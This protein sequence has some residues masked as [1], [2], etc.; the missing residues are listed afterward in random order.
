M[1]VRTAVYP[2]IQHY[3]QD[4]PN[5][6]PCQ[7]TARQ[8]PRK[9]SCGTA[10]CRYQPMSQQPVM[11]GRYISYMPDAWR[12]AWCIQ[13]ARGAER[14]RG[15]VGG[16]G[17]GEG[18]HQIQTAIDT[19]CAHRQE[20][21]GGRGSVGGGGGGWGSIESHRQ[22]TEESHRQLTEPAMMHKRRRCCRAGSCDRAGTHA[23]FRRG[24]REGHSSRA[25][26]QGIREG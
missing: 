11:T 15:G 8:I 26:E 1:A 25:F 10:A 9:Q 4:A 14:G 19:A 21:G 22:S 7:R 16:G 23:G 24:I 17:R 2:S 6:P 12:T 3:I 18:E 20:G 5:P 13:L